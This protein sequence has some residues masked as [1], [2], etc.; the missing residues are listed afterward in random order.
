M[1]PIT[2]VGVG[3]MGE[4]LI[5]GLKHHYTIS[6][7]NA[8]D[9]A[10]LRAVASKTP[11]TPC[12]DDAS[13]IHALGVSAAVIVACKPHHVP[14]ALR[15]L[16]PH[17]RPHTVVISVAAGVP[18]ASIATY[19]PQG[20]PIVR[21]MPNTS[22]ALRK[23]VTAWCA[24]TPVP[25]MVRTLFDTLGYAIEVPESLMHAVTAISGSGPAYV[26]AMMEALIATAHHRGI[27]DAHALVAHTVVGAALRVLGG[28]HPEALRTAVTSPNGTTAAA[29]DVLAPLGGLIDRAV[30][31]A[32]ARAQEMEAEIGGTP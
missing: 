15:F 29:L 11:I 12:M 10:R 23:G 2:I 3:A 21:A 7:Y 32:I 27:P 19:V 5:H 24:H 9:P 26:Y 31:A 6:A 28:A 17:I 16:A 18:L 22:C 8:G 1:I 13:R 25:P 4:A 30:D 14:D 20:Q